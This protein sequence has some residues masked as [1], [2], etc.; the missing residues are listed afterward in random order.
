M[1]PMRMPAPNDF[2][3][4]RWLL[5]A[6]VP[7]AVIVATSWLNR[8]NP[9]QQERNIP[10][11]I[12]LKRAQQFFGHVCTNC[13]RVDR[14]FAPTR[15]PSLVD[16]ASVA[17]KR[18]PGM[19]ASQYVLESIVDPAAYRASG[20]FG[21]MPERVVQSADEATIRGLVAYILGENADLQEISRLNVPAI[22]AGTG[23]PAISSRQQVEQGQTI[24]EGKGRCID[25]HGLSPSLG[26]ELIAPSLLG[27]GQHDEAYLRR[28]ILHPNEATVA[29]Y[30]Q[31]QVVLETGRVITGRLLYKADDYATFLVVSPT[32][33]CVEVIEADDL[34]GGS[35]ALA[36]LR[37]SA[38]SAMPG[39]YAELLTPQEIDA[40]IRFLAAL[41]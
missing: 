41:R 27:V 19:A 37:P 31:Y 18:R 4:L 39:N 28:A 25:C 10:S 21:T 14:T 2:W 23:K 9:Q 12:N 15:G 40:L 33:Y 26:T 24:F 3:S 17:A 32:G 29:G 22:K 36:Q 34:E 13:H 1:F 11:N 7:S 5:A 30:Q 6:L 16:F 38:T 20:I 35:E 8:A